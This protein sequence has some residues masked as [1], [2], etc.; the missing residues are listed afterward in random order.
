MLAPAPVRTLTSG[1]GDV[2]GDK[3]SGPWRSW[4][5]YGAQPDLPPANQPLEDEC[6]TVAFLNQTPVG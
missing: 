4:D 6:Q 3:R 2:P 5:H 1:E